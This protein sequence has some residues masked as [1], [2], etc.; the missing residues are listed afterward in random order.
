MDNNANTVTRIR[1]LESW[2]HIPW[3]EIVAYRELLWFIARR[4]FTVVY[5]QTILGPVWFII[6]PLLTTLVFTVV[7]GRVAQVRT[8]DL[9]RFL[10]YLSGTVF[11]NYFQGCMTT[12]SGTL[13]NNAYLF[14][15]VYFPRLLMP[16]ASVITNLARLLLSLAIYGC[17]HLYYVWDGVMPLLPSWGILAL[18]LL[19][20]ECA[21][22]GLGSGLWISALTAKYRD[23]QFA[24]PFLTQLWMY[25]TPVVYPASYVRATTRW[26]WSLNPMTPIV[27][28]G[29]QVLLGRSSI[30]AGMVIIGACSATLLC[31]SGILVF[32]RVQRNFVDNI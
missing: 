10:F 23:L 18:P 6:T 19:V 12:S 4:D 22:V 20:L 14:G 28:A 31:L 8:D 32:N 2:W 25:A 24:V 1:P 7:F 17:A 15:K 30:D 21:M 5:K 11:W 29:R 26:I 13:T 3:E 16:C 9:P 27:E